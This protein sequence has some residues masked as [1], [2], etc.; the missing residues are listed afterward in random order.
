MFTGNSNVFSQSHG[1][2][3]FF[4]GACTFWK[5]PG[6]LEQPGGVS[7]MNSR[8]VDSTDVGPALPAPWLVVQGS[9]GD[10]G[11]SGPHAL[12][13]LGWGLLGLRAASAVVSKR[14]YMSSSGPG[15]PSSC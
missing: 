9:A 12:A 8:Q 7:L 1:S 15:E 4:P 6:P 14:V 13:P 3:L 11:F 2:F 5:S 10:S